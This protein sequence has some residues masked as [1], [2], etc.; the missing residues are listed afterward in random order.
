[1]EHQLNFKVV[2]SCALL[3]HALLMA[4]AHAIVLNFSFQN[5]NGSVPGTVSG[6]ITLPDGDGTFAASSLVITSSPNALGY[7]LPF[8]VFTVFP[9]DIANTFVVSGGQIQA[10]S[11]FAR[12]SISGA[13]TLNYLTL[14]SLLTV[15]G[16]I[17]P[18]DGV[19]DT[20]NSTLAYGSVPQ[21]AVPAPLPIVGAGAALG[22]SRKLRRRIKDAQAQEE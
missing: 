5:V 10:S 18:T 21:S 20:T 17:G 11:T 3:L 9:Q 19:L 2:S 13:F 6:E 4:P 14:G 16:A 1:M 8:D 22:W 7:T 12:Q 15:N